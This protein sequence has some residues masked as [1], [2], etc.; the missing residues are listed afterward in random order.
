MHDW[1]ILLDEEAD[2][3]LDSLYNNFK[4]GWLRDEFDSYVNRYFGRN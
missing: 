2:K 4:A 3:N 1:L